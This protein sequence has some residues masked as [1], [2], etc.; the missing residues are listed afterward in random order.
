MFR[1][2]AASA[3][4]FIAGCSAEKPEV[5]D[6]ERYL[7]PK[8]K[9]PATYKRVEGKSYVDGKVAKVFIT[10]DAANSYGTP[11]RGIQMCQYPIVNG[12]PDTGNYIDHD[13]VSEKQILGPVNDAINAAMANISEP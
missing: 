7:M 13:A 3:L 2:L 9:A 10:Y 5:E 1:L 8:L 12:S 6:C 4:I 11:I